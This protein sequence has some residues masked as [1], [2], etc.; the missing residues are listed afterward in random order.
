MVEYGL[1]TATVAG[2]QPSQQFG[3]AVIE[4][5]HAWQQVERQHRRHRHRHHQRGQRRH[6][7]SDAERHEQASFHTGQREQRQEDQHDDDGRVKDGRPDF[8]RGMSNQFDRVHPVIVML[9]PILLQSPQD[10]FNADHGIIDQ[11][12]DGDGQTA[13]RHG[14]DRQPVILEDQRRHEDRHRN[15][16]QRDHR[17]AQRAQEEKQDDGDEHRGADQLAL[18]SA[19]GG[20]NETG[21]A[22]GHL[23]RFHAS[24]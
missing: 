12:A 10:V 18:Q 16:G 21:L 6:D 1:Q 11:P 22:E 9:G 4:R 5:F 20:F 2:L 24:R 13:Q 8:H 7:K 14:V 17:W 15:G 19:D 23:R 3:V